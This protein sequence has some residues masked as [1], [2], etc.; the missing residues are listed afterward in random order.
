MIIFKIFD[1][2]QYN[3][4]PT[5]KSLNVDELI[6]NHVT[7][8]RY[9]HEV[10]N[11]WASADKIETTI[12]FD[13]HNKYIIPIWYVHECELPYSANDFIIHVN[14]FIADYKGLL[15]HA[16]IA[17]VDP[18]ESSKHFIESVSKLKKQNNCNIIGINPNKLYKD[19][20]Y[21]DTGLHMVNELENNISFTNKKLYINLNNAAR[22]HRCKMLDALIENNL[23][24]LGYNT[25]HDVYD[26]FWKYKKNNK[27]Q[28]DKIKWDILDSTTNKSIAKRTQ[29]IPYRCCVQSFLWLVVET[30]VDSNNLFF[31]E[32]IYKPI[33]LGMPFIVLGNPGMLRDLQARGYKTF[34]EYWNEDYDK[35]MSLDD[36]IKIIV[37]NLQVLKNKNLKKIHKKLQPH[38]KHN[39]E[40]YKKERSV[41]E[42]RENLKE[43][44]I[45][46][47]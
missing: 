9:S 35:D 18:Y 36:K 26:E 25:F 12:D 41:N 13:K 10:F 42:L 15:K 45:E 6:N 17:I 47:V 28:I 5:Q 2:R 8:D 19:G 16:T 21:S 7:L 29:L 1:S 30:N 14:N 37:D 24:T 43:F 44:D 4:S 38:L 27:T 11:F 34:K 22:Y 39:R 46:N 40:L 3:L 31:T 33:A 20:V 32:K 23:H